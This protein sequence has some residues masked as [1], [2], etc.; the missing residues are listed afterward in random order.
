MKN[1]N[2]LLAVKCARGNI[3]KAIVLRG[4]ISVNLS[5]NR[6]ANRT[7]QYQ[8]KN[9]KLNTSFTLPMVFEIKNHYQNTWYFGIFGF[10]G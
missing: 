3:K 2:K 4:A 1:K 5:V 9:K 10:F 7:Y 8:N 6:S